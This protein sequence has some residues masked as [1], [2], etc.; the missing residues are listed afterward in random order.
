MDL[1]K[2][3]TRMEMSTKVSGIWTSVKAKVRCDLP[4][5]PCMREAGK[6]TISM[7]KGPWSWCSLRQMT[8]TV[9]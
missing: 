5:V 9:F 7:A 1:A 6:R 3:Q 8:K 4:G 2:I